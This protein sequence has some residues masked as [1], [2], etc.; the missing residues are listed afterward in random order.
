M[1]RRHLLLGLGIIV[2]LAALV[3]IIPKLACNR[4]G[5]HELT[6]ASIIPL[7]GT[8]AEFGGYNREA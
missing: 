8:A 2:V 7:T 5:G 6:I 4:N 1:K 3:I